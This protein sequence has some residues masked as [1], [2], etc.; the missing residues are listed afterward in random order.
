MLL[1]SWQLQQHEHVH[2]GYATV[3]ANLGALICE[4]VVTLYKDVLPP[5][6]TVVNHSGSRTRPLTCLQSGGNQPKGLNPNN[7][8]FHPNGQFRNCR[9]VFQSIC[10]FLNTNS[11]TSGL[12][13]LLLETLEDLP[14]LSLSLH[15][16]SSRLTH[17]TVCQCPEATHYAARVTRMQ[18]ARSSIAQQW[19]TPFPSRPDGG[20]SRWHHCCKNLHLIKVY[21]KRSTRAHSH[22]CKMLKTIGLVVL[23]V[24]VNKTKEI[25]LNARNNQALC[26]ECQ[27]V[28]WRV[29]EVVVSF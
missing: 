1:L 12:Q 7:N 15:I 16:L 22:E 6:L 25:R 5:P 18:S 4:S 23:K 24:N 14:P 26:Q 9:K 19:H 11:K 21:C 17:P 8:N 28:N 29:V 13:L 10:R 2:L 20:H 27:E 3:R